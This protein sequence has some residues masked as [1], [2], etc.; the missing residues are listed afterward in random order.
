ME[1]S[2]MLTI[3]VRTLADSEARS[4]SDDNFVSLAAI[5]LVRASI[6]ARDIIPVQTKLFFHIKPPKYRQLLFLRLSNA[7]LTWRSITCRNRP[8][9]AAFPPETKHEAR[10]W[11][12]TKNRGL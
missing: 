7:T 10:V 9:S 8:W 4:A 12:N 11:P 2:G 6:T 1:F 5:G 3:A